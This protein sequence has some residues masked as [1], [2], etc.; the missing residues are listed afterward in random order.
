MQSEDETSDPLRHVPIFPCS[1]AFPN[2]PVCLNVFEPYYRSLIRR[3]L[4]NGTNR[5]GMTMQP[6][7]YSGEE[8]LYGTMLQV[9]TVR[10]HA[11][12]RSSVETIGTWRFKI[13]SRTWFDGY[14]VA[15]LER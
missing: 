8:V 3:I 9:K 5:F 12:G 7:P 13:L 10:M 1:L 15:N 14:I 11:D 4:A 2:Q 6:N